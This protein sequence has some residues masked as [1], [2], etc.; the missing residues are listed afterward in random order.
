MNRLTLLAASMAVFAMAHA[1]EPALAG[2]ELALV[3]MQGQKKVL[4][5]L[6]ASVFSPRVSPDGRQ[7]VFELADPPAAPDAPSVT[8]LYVAELDKLDQRRA[9]PPAVIA[10]R[11]IAGVWSPDG[12]WIAFLATG[13][14]NDA[15]FRLRSVGSGQPQYLVDGRAPEGWYTNGRLGFITRTGERDYG[16]SLLDMNTGTVSKLA[17]QPGSDQH[18]SRLSPDEK[19]IAYASTETGRQEVWVE[20][21]PQTGKRFQLTSQGGRHPQ[22]SPD[23]KQL[24]YDQDGRMYRLDL[25]FDGGTPKAGA[26]VQLPISGF[27]QGDLRRQY[28]L[29]PDG[30]GFVMLYP[31]NSPAP[32]AAAK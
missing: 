31:D 21:L 26:P 20:P 25:S 9:L 29:M 12:Q 16:I 4:G 2:F 28:D 15:L 6:P 19:W 10:Q 13:N 17:D 8:R 7:V 1:G 22:W 27:Q 30:S 11:N 5:K 32:P 18:S 3:D 24:Y 14:G 23:G